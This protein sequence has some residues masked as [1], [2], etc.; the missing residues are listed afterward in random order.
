MKDDKS[1]SITDT[2]STKMNYHSDIIRYK[3]AFRKHD[4]LLSYPQVQV[5]MVTKICGIVYTK[6]QNSMQAAHRARSTNGIH[7]VVAN[8]PFDIQLIN[9]CWL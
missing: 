6:L 1:Q 3:V 8:K 4:T 5:K 2:P 9:F 7:E